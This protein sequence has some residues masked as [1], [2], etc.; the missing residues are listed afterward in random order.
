MYTLSSEGETKS[1]ILVGFTWS[2]KKSEAKK[3]N[4]RK[5]FVRSKMISLKDSFAFWS[6]RVRV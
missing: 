3:N 5:Q 2:L 4:V 6:V 1:F